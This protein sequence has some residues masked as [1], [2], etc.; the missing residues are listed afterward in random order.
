MLALAMAG[1][2]YSFL[3]RGRMQP[4]ASNFQRMKVLKLTDS[5]NV[6]TASI[7]PD[8]RYVAYAIHE[9][10]QSS[11]WMR[12]VATESAVE[13]VSPAAA[14][15]FGVTFSSDGDYLYFVPNQKG[16]EDADAYIVP[17]LGGRPRLIL[18]DVDS[19]I[20]A[21]RDGKQ[22][23]FVRGNIPE[24]SQLLVANSDGT[25]EHV[26][27][28][29]VATKSGRFYSYA[30]PSWS[31]DGKLIALPIILQH[32]SG[33]FVTPAAGG[34]PTILASGNFVTSTSWL[35][36][37]S[38]LLINASTTFAGAKQIWQQPYPTGQPQRLT[39]DLN[40][41]P[42]AS[43]TADG[44]QFATVQVQSLITI[45]MANASTPDEGKPL[46]TGRSDGIGLAWLPDG[47]LLSQDVNSQLLGV[48]G[49]RTRSCRCS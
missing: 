11:L 1:A 34:Q 36:D 16:T 46:N 48:I 23:A 42:S 14:D 35:P 43:S 5:G 19:A 38:G 39:N 25:S 44:Q 26:V 4:V 21:S 49:R 41:Y 15:Y 12:Q 6:S 33:I 10:Q 22:I 45:F 27:A 28:D 30:A 3:R 9:G 13:L 18:R 24:V 31:A 20:G 8:G 17:V 40:S 32:F 47:K 7:S 2:G 29:T 37:Q